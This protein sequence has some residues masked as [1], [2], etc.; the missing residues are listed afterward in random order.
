MQLHW[1]A[2]Q[3]ALLVAMAAF[4]ASLM[5]GLYALT[6]A[7]LLTAAVAVVTYLVAVAKFRDRPD[8]DH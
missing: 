5:L 2:L 7:V 1:K 3:Y 8:P 4:V 6:Y